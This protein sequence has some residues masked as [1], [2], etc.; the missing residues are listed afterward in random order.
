MLNLSASAS[1]VIPQ[2][3]YYSVR[4]DIA[5]HQSKARV[6]QVGSSN[7]LPVRFEIINILHV[8]RPNRTN[9]TKNSFEC[10]NKHLRVYV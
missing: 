9:R 6:P 8:G 10:N 7:A 3:E 5:V 2:N 4:D 1:R